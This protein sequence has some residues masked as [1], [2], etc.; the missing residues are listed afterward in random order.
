MIL[1]VLFFIL[2][3]FAA[4]TSAMSLMEPVVEL[5]EEKTPLNR[6]AATVLAG[7]AT[8]ALGVAAL[9]SFNKWAEYKWFERNIFDLL[10][11]LTSKIMLPL[12]GLGII[13]FFGW[14]MRQPSIRDELNLK[15]TA[16][17]VWSLVA[18]I[19]APLLVLLI[20]VNQ[21]G[22]LDWLWQ[23]FTNPSA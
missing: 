4:L 7:V 19:I 22:G 14:F 16:W 8:W 18:K 10:D 3:T 15:G 12:T 13:V 1:G 23:W 2:L 17:A 20:F 5:L 11:A 6:V 9:L 21:L